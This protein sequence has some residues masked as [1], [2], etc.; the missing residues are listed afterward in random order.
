MNKKKAL[1]LILAK[2]IVGGRTREGGRQENAF[3]KIFSLFRIFIGLGS[4]DVTLKGIR[5]RRFIGGNKKFRKSD[6][7]R[8]N[9]NRK[10]I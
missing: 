6:D 2:S 10:K 1:M 5:N 4:R 3:G 8:G 9:K 7:L